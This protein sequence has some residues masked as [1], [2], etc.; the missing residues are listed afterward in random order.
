MV[1]S[2][3]NT[4]VKTRCACIQIVLGHD[5]LGQEILNTK[6]VDYGISKKNVDPPGMYI[7]YE[8]VNRWVNDIDR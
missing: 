3:Q 1:E 8:S 7:Q 2:Q 4:F 5:P 6:S